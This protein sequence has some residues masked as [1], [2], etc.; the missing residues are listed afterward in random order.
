MDRLESWR[1]RKEQKVCRETKREKG[2]RGCDTIAEIPVWQNILFFF[3]FFSTFYPLNK[4]LLPSPSSLL[5]LFSLFRATDDSVLVIIVT[6]S[7][8]FIFGKTHTSCFMMMRMRGWEASFAG[9]ERQ[10]MLFFPSTHSFFPASPSHSS[11][12][13][14]SD[15][16]RKH[17][18]AHLSAAH[19]HHHEG[20]EKEKNWTKEPH[21][22]FLSLSFFAASHSGF[23]SCNR[24]LWLWT[25]FFDSRVSGESDASAASNDRLQHQG[26][27]RR[28]KKG[29]RIG[30]WRKNS[31]SGRE[32]SGVL[33]PEMTITRSTDRN[34][35]PLPTDDAVDL[36]LR[37][38]SITI[39][40]S[41]L[42]PN[43]STDSVLLFVSS[44]ER[45]M[46]LVDEHMSCYCNDW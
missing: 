18:Q 38:F 6:L 44:E 33:H 23:S 24:S 35:M 43:S 41:S 29:C 15:T 27:R 46:Q 14:L 20:Q 7:F 11:S 36:G 16:E 37:F 5:L 45:K 4:T 39:S 42:M 28:R 3:V 8:I 25:T 12:F 30:V 32:K 40:F 1:R 9:P 13:T 34:A 31:G 26:V 2:I 17:T 21:H 10:V 19:H 22:P